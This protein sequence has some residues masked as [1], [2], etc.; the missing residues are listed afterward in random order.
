[1][2]QAAGI[3]NINPMDKWR[4]I[5]KM[6]KSKLASA[7]LLSSVFLVPAYYTQAATDDPT[8]PSSG[9][10]T[11]DESGA[12][13]MGSGS[14]EPDSGMGAGSTS[15][16]PSSSS[17]MTDAKNPKEAFKQL[18]KD[19]DGNVTQDEVSTQDPLLAGARKFSEYDKDK[20]GKLSE[21]EYKKYHEKEKQAS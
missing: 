15:S 3:I 18:D 10:A 6:I 16:E 13:G 12:S 11:Q 7:I 21:K 14:T 1:V 2:E 8:G 20:N 4:N 9:A 5:M 17:T 19:S